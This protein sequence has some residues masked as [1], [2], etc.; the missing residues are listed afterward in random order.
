VT[1]YLIVSHVSPSRG[2]ADC[3]TQPMA[4]FMSYSSIY[5]I[6]CTVT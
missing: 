5:F 1:G 2:P 6:N 4:T 3:V